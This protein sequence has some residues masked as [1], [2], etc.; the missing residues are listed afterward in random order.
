MNEIEQERERW[1][2]KAREVGEKVV[3]PRAR[4][5]DETGEFPWDIVRTF[6][7][8]GFLSLLIPK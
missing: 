1:R 4:E 7:E 2:K 3:A 5:V 6:H 8:E